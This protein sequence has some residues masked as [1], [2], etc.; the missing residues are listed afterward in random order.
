MN[1]DSSRAQRSIVSSKR[2]MTTDFH[3]VGSIDPYSRGAIKLPN[4]KSLLFLEFVAGLQSQI[5]E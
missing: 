4:A 1:I 2:Y 5:Q 3:E